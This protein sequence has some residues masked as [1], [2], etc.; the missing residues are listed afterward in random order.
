MSAEEE[1]S[2][3]KKNIWHLAKLTEAKLQTEAR[4]RQFLGNIRAS[5]LNASYKLG[6]A[7]NDALLNRM[8]S[9]I[10]A[11][12]RIERTW[13]ITPD[14]TVRLHP[15]VYG[16][17]ERFCTG[18]DFQYIVSE[19]WSLFSSNTQRVFEHV[20][21]TKPERFRARYFEVDEG[22]PAQN[23]HC[24]AAVAKLLER[25]AELRRGADDAE[26][27]YKW[28]TLRRAVLQHDFQNECFQGYHC[29]YQ[30]P[31][32]KAGS[33]YLDSQSALHPPERS[34]SDLRRWHL[35]GAY[36]KIADNQTI[37]RHFELRGYEL[38][39]NDFGG[40][41]FVP[42]CHQAILLGA[43]GEEAVSAV[44]RKERLI[45]EELPDALFELADVKLSGVPWYIDCKNYSASTIEDIGLPI[46]DPSRR[47]PLNEQS[48]K[49]NALRKREEL[50]PAAKLIYLNLFG[51]ERPLR[52]FDSDFVNEVRSLE[53]ASFV[54]VQG[55]L[56]RTDPN[57]YTDAFN[58][59]L[60]D[61]KKLL[62]DL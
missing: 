27:R 3:I 36:N 55:V 2:I 20:R 50:E 9:Y 22:L 61:T 8:S 35:S 52:Y 29:T 10:Q 60:M 23:R 59:F 19:R 53:D 44:L 14:Q 17:F 56:N 41:F 1:R 4:F 13:R 6:G 40:Y 21:Q 24:E 51:D 45:L 7:A 31:H 58:T 54:I 37:R 33:L 46:D 48:F 57:A 42:Y 25:L 47:T 26:A 15:D 5:H 34:S 12:G 16:D 32:L 38:G 30:Y 62:E 39:F 18:D 43:I 11:L 49:E 28:Q